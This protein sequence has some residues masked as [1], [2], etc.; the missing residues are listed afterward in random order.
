MPTATGSVGPPLDGIA[1][2]A[3]IGGKLENS[4]DN[5]MAWIAHPQAVVPGNAMPEI[6]MKQAELRDLAAFLYTRS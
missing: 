1:E 6:P 2:R 4:P 3:I 5:L